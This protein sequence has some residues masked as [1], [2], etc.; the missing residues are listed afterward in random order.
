MRWKPSR[1]F[2]PVSG[3]V[4]IAI[5]SPLIAIFVV[6][7]GAAWC[8]EKLWDCKCRLLGPDRTWRKWFA[9]HPVETSCWSERGA[10]VFW[11]ETVERTKRGGI[12]SFRFPGDETGDF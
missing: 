7:F 5:A 10:E 12:T 4:V 8:L 2:G 9:W 1:A 6:A 3:P 11:L